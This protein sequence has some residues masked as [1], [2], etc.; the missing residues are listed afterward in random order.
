[1][2]LHNGL[3][4]EVYDLRPADLHYYYMSFIEMDKCHPIMWRKKM[5]HQIRSN[6]MYVPQIW[7]I[8]RFYIAEH[9]SASMILPSR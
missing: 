3:D 8:P 9:V 4:I 5:I 7:S 2:D 6:S 1:M